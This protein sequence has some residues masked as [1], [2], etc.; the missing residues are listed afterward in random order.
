MLFKPKYISKI[1]FDYFY[2]ICTIAR[3]RCGRYT[4]FPINYAMQQF[5]LSFSVVVHVSIHRLCLQVHDPEHGSGD[6]SLRSGGA[7][8]LRVPGHVAVLYKRGSYAH[9]FRRARLQDHRGELRLGRDAECHREPADTLPVP[10]RHA[11]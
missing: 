10:R 6:A 7:R 5:Y 9:T 3:L 11:G 1:T 8:Q 2:E 4:Y